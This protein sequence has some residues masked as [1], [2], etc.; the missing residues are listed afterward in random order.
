MM[1]YTK[2]IK[3]GYYLILLLGVVL[4]IVFFLNTSDYSEVAQASS[5][6]FLDIYLSWGYILLL[7]NVVAMMI[8]PLPF[9]TKASYKRLGFLAIIGIVLFAISYMMASPE[10]VDAVV[11]V[12]PTETALK[13]TDTGL[14][15]TYILFAIALLSI[16]F[17]SVYKS[18]ILPRLSK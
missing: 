9:M 4:T 18:F 7:L 11:K 6:S 13:L 14:I 2:Y 3:Y 17:S 16:V 8:L 12:P 5:F 15:F 1:T 10:S